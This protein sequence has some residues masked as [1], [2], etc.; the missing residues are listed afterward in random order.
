VLTGSGAA[1][2]ARFVEG[3]T[4][5]NMHAVKY[6]AQVLLHVERPDGVERWIHAGPC[7]L[8]P[9]NTLLLVLISRTELTDSHHRHFCHKI[10]EELCCTGALKG[11]DEETVNVLECHS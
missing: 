5:T 11:P 8:R 1:V 10:Q 9:A 4:R 2:D 7:Y 3:G 6:P